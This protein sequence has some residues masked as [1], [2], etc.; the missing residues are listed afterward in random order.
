MTKTVA[1][2]FAA[3]GVVAPWFVAPGFVAVAPHFSA[4]S[5]PASAPAQEKM[6]TYQLVLLKKG[7]GAMDK[8][9]LDAHGAYMMKLGA[10]RTILAAGPFN[11]G[12]EIAGAI[13]M[14]VTGERAREIEG[15]DPAV[16]AGLFTMEILS[17]MAPDGWFKPWAQ[18]FGQETIYFGFLNRG[19]NRSQ[20]AETAARLQKEHLAYMNGQA[21]TGKLVLAGPLVD[22]GDR[23]GIVGYRVATPQE[24]KERAQGDPM[25]K[26][27][28]LAVELHPW[29]IPK[30]AL[31]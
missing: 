10:E 15:D 24:A 20:D 1:I 13:V 31:K 7:T 17:F 25:V 6:V 4:A 28:R 21:E 3:L 23:R 8:K 26:V 29:S 19:P 11:D 18:P 5:A 12:G 14:G 16:K 30:G 9:T 2:L 27:G 22:A